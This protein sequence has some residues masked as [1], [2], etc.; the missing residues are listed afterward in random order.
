MGC[1]ASFWSHPKKKDINTAQR[2]ELFNVTNQFCFQVVCICF[3][4]AKPL[5]L[6]EELRTEKS[7]KVSYKTQPV[8]HPQRRQ[9]V[10][11][12]HV[13]RCSNQSFSVVWAKALS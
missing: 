6:P 8:V 10:L 1:S 2:L 11:S 4:A 13:S 12:E 5:H 3:Y 7:L 9:G